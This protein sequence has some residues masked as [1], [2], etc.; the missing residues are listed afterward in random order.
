LREPPPAAKRINGMKK[1]LVALA[2]FGACSPDAEGDPK[3]A[4]GGAAAPQ[5]KADPKPAPGRIATLAGLYEGGT[6]KQKHQMCVVEGSGGSQRFGLVVWGNGMHSC[7]GSGTVSREGNVLKL[8]MAGDSACTIE[9]AISGK[10]V[11]LPQEVPSGCSYY[12]GA[13]AKLGGAELTQV[14]TGKSDAMKAKDLVGEPL[15]GD[16]AD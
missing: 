1:I 15:C 14:G 2:L 16:E 12:C 13:Q 10:T 7:S 3:P 6:G 11:K 4:P 9:A 5:A 8:A